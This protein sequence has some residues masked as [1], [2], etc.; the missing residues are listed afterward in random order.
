MLNFEHILYS[1]H[2]RLTEPLLL[3]NLVFTGLPYIVYIYVR[4]IQTFFNR[5]S[6]LFLKDDPKCPVRNESIFQIFSIKIDCDDLVFF[7]LIHLIIR[8]LYDKNIY[9]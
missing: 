8:Q 2:N 9:D 5:E 4:C 7:P 1:P 6:L 3:T